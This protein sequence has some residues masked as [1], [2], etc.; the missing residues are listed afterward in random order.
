MRA[1]GILAAQELYLKQYS[2][3]SD[4][5]LTLYVFHGNRFFR[6]ERHRVDAPRRAF[7][8]TFCNLKAAHSPTVS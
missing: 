5:H 1:S 8:V 2:H 3:S 4:T 6:I 7:K